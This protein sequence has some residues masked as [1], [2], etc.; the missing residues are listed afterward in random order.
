MSWLVLYWLLMYVCFMPNKDYVMLCYFMYRLSALWVFRYVGGIPVC[1]WYFG[2][3]VVFRYVGGISVNRVN[4]RRLWYRFWNSLTMCFT[5]YWFSCNILGQE[6]ATFQIT[7]ISV[8][9][10]HCRMIVE[11]SSFICRPQDQLVPYCFT[12]DFTSR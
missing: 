3:S 12:I 11:L 9:L 7:V 10:L 6:I 5:V 4:E 2:M 8:Q 1:R